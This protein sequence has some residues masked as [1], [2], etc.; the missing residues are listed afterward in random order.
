MSAS[1]SA[2][3]QRLV[4]LCAAL[5]EVEV[6]GD[7]HLAFRVRGKTLGYYL[8]DHH[9]DGLISLCC[10]AAPGDLDF[11]TLHAPDRYYTPAYLGSRGW[12]AL[13]LDTPSVDWNEVERL[14]T[15][16]YALTAPRRLAAQVTVSAGRPVSQPATHR[17]PA[18]AKANP[19]KSDLP[20]TSVPATRALELAGITR[21]AQL[22]KMTEAEL[23]ALHGIGP[24]AVR[25]WREALAERGLAFKPE[26]PKPAKKV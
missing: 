12:V 6:T 11:L 19:P 10:K 1:P 14:L 25:I 22:T 3:R 4:R 2:R 8:N 20:K 7:H 16:A 5:P 18:M 15:T 21:L 17:S 23:L 13:R 26:K 24:K 9:G